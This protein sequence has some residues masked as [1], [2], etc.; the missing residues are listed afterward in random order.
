MD[1]SEL[2]PRPRHLGVAALTGKWEQ[3]DKRGTQATQ[4]VTKMEKIL[5]WLIK[6]SQ[7]NTKLYNFNQQKEQQIVRATCSL[8]GS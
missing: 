7:K 4:W 3:G 8:Q 6:I 2:L 1:S 5:K